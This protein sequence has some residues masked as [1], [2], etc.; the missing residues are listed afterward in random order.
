MRDAG[1]AEPTSRP[2]CPTILVNGT[3]TPSCGLAAYVVEKQCLLLALGGH[4][5]RGHECPLLGVKRTSLFA[6]QMSAY[7]L[8]RTSTSALHMSAFDP[9]RTF[10]FCPAGA[11]GRVALGFVGE[12]AWLF[13]GRRFT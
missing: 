3:G 9:K 10:A 11:S 6:L 13:E 8:K 5:D 2:L 12:S 4:F 1:L 7:D